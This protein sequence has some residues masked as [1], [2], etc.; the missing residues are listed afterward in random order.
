MDGDFAR[1]EAR[2]CR[3]G[4]AEPDTVV[5]GSAAGAVEWNRHDPD[6]GALEP[7]LA[8]G[9][10]GAVL[11]ARPAQPYA[12]VLD[13]LAA[14]ADSG[15]IRPDDA[16]SRVFLKD[17]PVAA[18]LEA[19]ALLSAL[20]SRKCVIVP[21]HG[22]V[23]SGA[24]AA[25]AY[26]NFSA[27]CF[28]GFVKF[29]F[30]AL[31][32]ARAGK[33]TDSLAAA[34]FR[35]CKHLPP[36][37]VFGGGL[38]KGPFAAGSQVRSA[39]CEAGREVVKRGLV[40][41]CF[42]NISYRLGDTLYISASG[43][44]LDEL[45]NAVV[46]IS[47]KDGTESGSNPSSE[48]PAHRE[49]AVST[50]FQAV[51]HGHPLFSMILSMDC[52]ETD[53]PQPGDCYRRCVAEGVFKEEFP[54]NFAVFFCTSLHGLIQVRKLCGTIVERED[55]DTFFSIQPRQADRQHKQPVNGRILGRGHCHGKG[56]FMKIS[57]SEPLCDQPLTSSTTSSAAAH[58][59]FPQEA[60]QHLAGGADRNLFHKF[61]FP[62]FLVG[63]HL[64]VY[65]VHK[66][67]FAY[68]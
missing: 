49:I 43:S 63:H 37:A 10:A 57:W 22:I 17:L 62:Q 25:E 13:Y 18:G 46:A 44:F 58:L 28:S 51:L 68:G 38:M 54:G 24:D 21:G 20:E 6:R 23:A 40:D 7:L 15:V 5:F 45:D 31:C 35:A 36:P 61:H 12:S 48:L 27:A 53:C 30:D 9:Q 66:R 64:A 50:N 1:Y 4:L 8:H 55:F 32:A 29:F 3:N 14:H 47:L 39:I 34:F 16:E 41:A 42:G 65:I 60:F 33:V 59:P 11:H 56:D 19:G 2:L 67:C 52:R 26:V